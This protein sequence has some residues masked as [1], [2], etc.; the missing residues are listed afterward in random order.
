M[1]GSERFW[2]YSLLKDLV[3]ENFPKALERQE[4]V[5][6]SKC[7]QYQSCTK[8]SGF[9]PAPSNQRL[10]NAGKKIEEGLRPKRRELI[11]LRQGIGFRDHKVPDLRL[12]SRPELFVVVP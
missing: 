2:G 9:S 8:S 6:F 7:R 5:M 10:V 3:S 11:C 12:S 4:S 1:A